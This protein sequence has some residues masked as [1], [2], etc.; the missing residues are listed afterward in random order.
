MPAKS[1][2]DTCPT[3]D[4]PKTCTAR[5]CN[6]CSAASR[7]AAAAATNHANTR[8]RAD[9]YAFLVSC[10]ESTLAALDRVGWT[11]GAAARWFHRHGRR[12][13]ARAVESAARAAR[14]GRWAPRDD[15]RALVREWAAEGA[16]A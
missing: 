7:S 2:R 10:G 15:L 8:T 9:D 14:V 6:R 16:A 12:P 4:G 13:E 5:Q 1:R 3:C 11:P